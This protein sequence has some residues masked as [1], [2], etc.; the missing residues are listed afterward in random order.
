M[1]RFSFGP[2]NRFAPR[3]PNRSVHSH[4][5]DLKSDPMNRENGE[6][7]IALLFQLRLPEIHNAVTRILLILPGSACRSLSRVLPLHSY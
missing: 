2:H 6:P 5:K 3:T 1:V 7:E 4:P